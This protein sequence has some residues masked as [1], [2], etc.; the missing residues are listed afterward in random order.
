MHTDLIRAR[1]L[2]RRYMMG[3]ESVM[4]RVG[5]IFQSFNLIPTRSAIENVEIPLMLARAGRRER[6]E[7]AMELL[8]Q[9][10]LGRRARHRPNELSGGEMQRVAIA[11]ALA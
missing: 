3:Q 8:E 5:F 6:H 2:A 7:R 9:V 1:S 10:G 11:R 4:A